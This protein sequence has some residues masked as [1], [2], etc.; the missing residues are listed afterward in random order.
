[1]GGSGLVFGLLGFIFALSAL[2][3]IR[4]LEQR[5]KDAWV[6]FIK[7]VFVP[8]RGAVFGREKTI[9]TAR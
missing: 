9:V 8:V 5:L 1:V 7:T 4:R 6:S 3:K 2:G